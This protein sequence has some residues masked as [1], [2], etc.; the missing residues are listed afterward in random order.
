MNPQSVIGFG[1]FELDLRRC[2]LTRAGAAVPIYPRPFRALSYLIEHRDR[3]VTKD[4]LMEAVWPGTIVS[5]SS[6]STA[7]KEVRRALGD[8]GQHQRWIKTARGHGF[9]FVG[10]V[11]DSADDEPA[12]SAGAD[13]T[14]A[15]WKS[16]AWQTRLS[17]ARLGVVVLIV[18]FA[19]SFW[20][21]QSIAHPRP[22]SSIAVLPFADLSPGRDHGYLADGISEEL[23]NALAQ[24]P[25]LRVTAR[26]SSF[27]FKEKNLDIREI[28]R[29][30]GVGAILEGSIQRTDGRLRVTAQ[31]INA[32]DGLHLWSDAWDQSF[33]ELFALR[34][35][36]I[37]SVSDH[38]QVNPTF[39]TGRPPTEN[40]R[41][42]ELSTRGYSFFHEHSAK[43]LRLAVDHFERAIE[44]DPGYAAAHTGLASTSTALWH[45]QFWYPEI[46]QP[47]YTA[48]SPLFKRALQAAMRS[49]ELGPELPGGHGA[50][51]YLLFAGLRDFTAAKRE[52]N[53]EEKLAPGSLW[54]LINQSLLMVE[55]G[56]L[57]EARTKIDR[58]RELDPLSPLVTQI[59]GEIYYISGEYDYAIELLERAANAGHGGPSKILIMSY[60]AAGRADDLLRVSLAVLPP[61]VSETVKEVFE[62]DGMPGLLRYRLELEQAA[63]GRLCGDDSFLSAGFFVVLEEAEHALTCLEVAGRE[64][65]VFG[66]KST[67]LFAQYR[68]NPRFIAILEH[69]GVL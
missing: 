9:R 11:R 64:N 62:R 44:L 10:T 22:P 38:L 27:A 13:R 5:D 69:V 57:G 39:E 19:A 48:N 61:D 55:L 40:L 15:R 68:G 45:H 32:E 3:Y 12:E 66:V 1:D 4:E 37:H 51:G 65:N 6:L 34:N 67:P 26:T 33:D 56:Q 16:S 50:L 53:L 2:E 8:N 36:I 41:A 24:N 23:I 28:G 29:R 31:L 21:Q 30:L 42:Y 17:A 54:P 43:S 59:A 60:L 46:E 47:D 58:A 18:A 35:K 63:S 25:E 49:V 20:W 7:L 14:E 52:M